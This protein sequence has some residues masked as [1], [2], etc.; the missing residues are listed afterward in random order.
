[1][2]KYYLNFS[3]SL[4]KS[5]RLWKVRAED[6]GTRVICKY[7]EKA[8]KVEVLDLLNNDITPLGKKE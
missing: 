5:I 7:M 2:I 6:E 4:C 8:K 1:M 3:Y